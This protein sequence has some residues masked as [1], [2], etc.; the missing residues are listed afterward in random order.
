MFDKIKEPKEIPFFDHGKNIFK[1]IHNS[2]K[3]RSQSGLYFAIRKIKNIILFRIVYFCPF[4][5]IRIILHKWRGVNIGKNVQIA[6]Q[7]IIDNAY[8]EYVYIDDYAGVNQGAM[9]IAHTNVRDCYKGIVK[10]KV[11]SI[12]IKEYALVSINATILPG[13]EIGEYSIISAGS[14]VLSTI[15]PFSMAIGNPARVMAK[16]EDKIMNNIAKSK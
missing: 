2:S 6:Q 16:Y 9:L 14:V 1:T 12:H 8:P 15:K 10:C 4:N 3:R 11:A 7:V 5:S 13:V